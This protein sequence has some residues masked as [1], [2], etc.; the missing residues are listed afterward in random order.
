MLPLV[1]V[2]LVP[3]FLLRCGS[4]LLSLADDEA[5]ALGVHTGMMRIVI[6][7]AATLMTAASVA[8]SGIIGWSVC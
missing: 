1:L 5:R 6:V 2:A 8:V 3:M 7:C 4:N